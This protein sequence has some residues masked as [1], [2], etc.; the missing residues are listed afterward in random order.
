M[1]GSRHSE[2][3]ISSMPTSRLLHAVHPRWPS[4]LEDVCRCN[5]LNGQSKLVNHRASSK[6]PFH[7]LHQSPVAVG[8]G[9]ARRNALNLET[10]ALN[11][12]C[13]PSPLAT[14]MTT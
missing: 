1:I 3:R 7:W 8:H 11:L 4:T 9:Q 5:V 13:R 10:H 14:T 6:L 12:V 2:P